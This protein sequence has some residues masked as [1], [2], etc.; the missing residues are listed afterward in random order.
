MLFSRP[1]I[2]PLNLDLEALPFREH[3]R[4]FSAK[5]TDGYPIHIRFS[6]GC[7]SAYKGEKGSEIKGLKDETLLVQCKIVPFGYTDI[8]PEQICDVLG[9]TVQGK[10]IDGPNEDQTKI[11]KRDGYH[12]GAFFDLSGKTTVWT[13][14]HLMLLR[15]DADGFVDLVKTVFPGCVMFQTKMAGNWKTYSYR[16][17]PFLLQT[18][19]FVSFGIGGKDKEIES[20]FN[21]GPVDRL[22]KKSVFP[23]T[24]GFGRRSR[25]PE[26]GIGKYGKDILKKHGAYKLGIRYNLLNIQEYSIGTEFETSN[27]F[28]QECISKL[29][30]AIDKYF[31]RGLSA[32]DMQTGELLRE[33]ISFGYDDESGCYSS[34]LRDWCL[35]KPNNYIWVGYEDPFTITCGEPRYA[36]ADDAV[37]YGIRPSK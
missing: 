22:A 3:M 12:G 34:A 20:F 15:E 1:H 7:L 24:F 26:G 36:K 29:L 30:G 32:Y 11:L 6:S 16:R 2:Q 23:F 5:T 13:S 9:L 33:N 35:E 37:F 18:D 31:H 4:G 25:A 28:A 8:M 17:I 19:D 21:K 27:A 10:K 14:T